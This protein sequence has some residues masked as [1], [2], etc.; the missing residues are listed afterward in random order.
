MLGRNK[1]TDKDLVKS[2][3]QKLSRAGASSQS[4]IA[5]TIQQGT[6]TLTGNLQYAGQRSPIVKSVS[7]V[8][9]VRRVVDLMQ[10]VERKR[11]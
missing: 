3:N 7:S 9:G 6:V 2:V 8:A 4:R 5:A 1:I 10:L 11:P